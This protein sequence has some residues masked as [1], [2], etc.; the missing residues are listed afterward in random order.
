VDRVFRIPALLFPVAFSLLLLAAAL[1]TIRIFSL[2][3]RRRVS[4]RLRRRVWLV[5]G[6]VALVGMAITLLYSTS[7][8]SYGADW[9]RVKQATS[10]PAPIYRVYTNL[11][12][13]P[14]TREAL[15]EMKPTAESDHDVAAAIIEAVASSGPAGDPEGLLAFAA[16]REGYIPGND[17]RYYGRHFKLVGTSMGAYVRRGDFGPVEE[18][19]LEHADVRL[20]RQY[21]S[22]TVRIPLRSSNK[23][24][25]IDLLLGQF[26]PAV[27]LLWAVWL[28]A[29]LIAL[30]V[31]R[32]RAGRW[33]RAGRCTG[34]GYQLAT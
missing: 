34:C 12:R 9:V 5:A 23:T 30:A 18:M 1:A 20:N 7:Q 19:P 33:R 6:L 24:F 31:L 3:R 28:A 2:V 17:L 32:R 13:L 22:V 10:P 16:V 8:R 27:L 14:L 21:A 4:A 15:L 26:I 29:R 11:A 25:S